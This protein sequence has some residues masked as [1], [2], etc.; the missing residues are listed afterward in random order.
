ML[1]AFYKYF[2]IVFFSFIWIL[3]ITL[4][5]QEWFNLRPVSY[6]GWKI[7]LIGLF[8][9]ISGYILFAIYDKS[10]I[11]DKFYFPVFNYPLLLKII[12]IG[13]LISCL[14]S[15]MVMKS[16]TGLFNDSIDAYFKSPIKVRLQYVDMVRNP[17]IATPILFKLGS[18]LINFSFITT[19]LGGILLASKYKYRLFGLLPI[20]AATL[21]SFAVLGRYTFINGIGFLLISYLIC[22][23][24][25][26]QK[27][28]KQNLKTLFLFVG[29]LGVVVT[30]IF[31]GISSIRVVSDIDVNE[32]LRKTLYYYFAS[33]PV[34]LDSFLN[35]DYKLLYGESGFRSIFKWLIRLGLWEE[36]SATGAFDN[37][38]KVSPSMSLNTYTHLRSIMVD[39]GFLGLLVINFIWGAMLKIT[40]KYCYH[41]FTLL[42]LFICTLFIFGS[43]MTFYSFY[44]ESLSTF[45]FWGISVIFIDKIFNLYSYSSEQIQD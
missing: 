39:F 36:S 22:S 19:I 15:F 34:A 1:N 5:L 24:F 10:F 8:S 6:D 38:V 2:P 43:L 25:D 33:G 30:G 31:Y 29:F 13:F 20:L 21:A 16:I 3:V 9:F 40:L 32:Y 18:Y 45:L 14:G 26:T 17:L 35:S 7:L 23:F 42:G 11:P 44:F 37:F 12:I 28:R 4:A 41:S 27:N